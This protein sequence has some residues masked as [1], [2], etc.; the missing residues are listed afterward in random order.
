MTYALDSDQEA[1]VERI[2]KEATTTGSSSSALYPFFQQLISQY[3]ILTDDECLVATHL[4]KNIVSDSNDSEHFVLM[5]VPD[6]NAPQ[7]FATAMDLL[8]LQWP[9]GKPQP[10]NNEE[11]HV[12]HIN[13]LNTES[14]LVE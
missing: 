14:D 10:W 6:E 8:V 2:V 13:D 4:T 3:S 12:L 5:P 11:E 7:E 9:N 1:H